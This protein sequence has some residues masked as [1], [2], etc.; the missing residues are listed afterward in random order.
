MPR[1]CPSVR[2][3]HS[4]DAKGTWRP[5]LI[6]GSRTFALAREKCNLDF[7]LLKHFWTWKHVFL[8][9]VDRERER[10]STDF[11][12]FE[13]WHVHLGWGVSRLVF[14]LF[15]NIEG[16]VGKTNS[17]CFEVYTCVAWANV[18]NNNRK[19]GIMSGPLWRQS[20]H[21]MAKMV[22]ETSVFY[23]KIQFFARFLVRKQ[24]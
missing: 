14:T 10:L 4:S 18:K 11:R 1:V 12:K 5:L 2:M 23:L 9:I 7:K 22:W 19:A 15:R 3:A 21:K 16:A 8:T 24:N 17:V 13:G 6:R 20:H